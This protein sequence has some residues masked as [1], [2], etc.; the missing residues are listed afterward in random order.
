MIEGTVT[1]QS[2]AA[3]ELVESGRF[4][5]VPAIADIDMDPWMEYLYNQQP[6]PEDITGVP[7][8]L[9]AIR[10]DGTE[11]D[12]GYVISDK[13][14]QYGRMWTP[15]AQDTYRIV[16]TFKTTDSYWTSTAETLLGV[17][18]ASSPSGFMEPELTEQPTTTP[19]A[20]SGIST[21]VIIVAVVAIAVLIGAASY[22][23]LRKRK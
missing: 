4:S 6:K 1:D 20:A 13:N 12:L 16:A 18:G 23:A 10:S 5:M 15:P 11:I 9:T 8:Y 14:G 3:K 7:V 21:E 17:T 19:A 22:I 2:P